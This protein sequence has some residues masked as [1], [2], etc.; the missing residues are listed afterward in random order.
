MVRSMFILAL[1]IFKYIDYR[2]HQVAIAIFTAAA[3]TQHI[4]V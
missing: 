3:S 1:E 4:L 2:S